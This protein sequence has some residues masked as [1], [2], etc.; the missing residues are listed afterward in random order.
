[1]KPKRTI[2]AGTALALLM[3][4]PLYPVS[5]S[6]APFNSGAPAI[7]QSQTGIPPIVLAQASIEELRRRLED[8]DLTEEER[9]AIEE[10]IQYPGQIR[11]TVIR[12]TRC[13]E[14]AK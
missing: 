9:E 7:P 13:V 1:M 6:A 4:A 3:T 14:F 11:V 2:A 12:E 5:S 10:Q 8:E